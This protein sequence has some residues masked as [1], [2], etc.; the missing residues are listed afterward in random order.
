MFESV[1]FA[2]GGHRCWWQVGWWSAVSE[3][4][5]LA[6]R[7][8]AGV[9]AGAA[10]ACL[11]YASDAAT[12]LAYYR[13]VLG[14]TARNFYPRHL[15]RRGQKVLPHEQI[16]RDA[17][18][19][20]LGGQAFERLMES[21]PPIRIMFARP[22]RRLPP[23]L[24]VA[25]G[26]A[27]YNIEKYWFRP[28]HPRFGVGLG[29]TPEIATVQSCRN[30]GELV[31]LIIASSSTP[32]F[33]SIQRIGGGPVL[34]GG[35]IDNVPVGALEVL[36]AV[37]GQPPA[38]S[39]PTTL[40][41]VTR[42]YRNFAPVFEQDGRVYVQPSEKVAASSWDYT[43]PGDYQATFDQGRRDAQLFL[44]WLRKYSSMEMQ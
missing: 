2:G 12:A 9:S 34:D 38:A 33:T 31:N 39:L 3:K 32:P 10:T 13:R 20:L 4:V 43:N 35:L 44:Q 36:E 7:Q 17:L 25:A 28:L 30:A 41:L 21:A 29:F 5:S 6:P 22:P 24:A 19:E 23:T 16:Y 42:R 14:P 40:V 37:A 26:L 15:F 18:S 11:L 1:V 8:I 27:A